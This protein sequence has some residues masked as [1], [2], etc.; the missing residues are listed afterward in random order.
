MACLELLALVWSVSPTTVDFDG[1]MWF[2]GIN[3]E[4]SH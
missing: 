3:Y 2:V 1:Q 4:L